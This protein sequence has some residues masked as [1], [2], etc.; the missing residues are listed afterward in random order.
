MFLDSW[1]ND[2]C[3]VTCVCSWWYCPVDGWFFPFW[4]S[5][6]QKKEIKSKSMLG[7]NWKDE[8]KLPLTF[9]PFTPKAY[10]SQ[11]SVLS[12]GT[13]LY[14]NM[15]IRGVLRS[16]QV[17]VQK[18]EWGGYLHVLAFLFLS[19]RGEDNH[20]IC[21]P[22]N[23]ARSLDTHITNSLNNIIRHR[24]STPKVRKCGFECDLKRKKLKKLLHRRRSKNSNKEN[25]FLQNSYA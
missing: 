15:F 7:P 4:K 22:W 8:W 13:A 5:W 24:E 18:N 1:Q 20:W 16:V 21:K 23:L 11:L 12:P 6:M 2:F 3:T 10:C 19:L 25:Y 14:N 9:L 17:D